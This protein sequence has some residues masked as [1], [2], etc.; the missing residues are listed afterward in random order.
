M[1]HCSRLAFPRKHTSGLQTSRI[2]HVEYD[3]LYKLVYDKYFFPPKYYYNKTKWSSRTKVLWI[4]LDV[5][6]K[7]ISILCF[8]SIFFIICLGRP[9]CFHMLCDSII[10]RTV[11]RLNCHINYHLTAPLNYK[12]MEQVSLPICLQ[13]K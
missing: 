11:K 4:K 9:T 13:V 6:R 10:R 7:P 2:S 8:L 5:L 1:I 3:A 12:L